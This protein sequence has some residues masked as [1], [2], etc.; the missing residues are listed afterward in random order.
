[1]HVSCLARTA[2]LLVLAS[3]AMSAQTTP[4]DVSGAEPTSPGLHQSAESELSTGA[5][6]SL[7][8]R[9][10]TGA[11]IMK[12][13]V[14]VYP[15]KQGENRYG[16]VTDASGQFSVQ[17]IAP[18]R[19][20]IRTEKVGY[21]AQDYGED[22]SGGPGAV[23]TLSSGQRINDLPFRMVAEGV[24]LGR[25]L[26]EDGAPV[27]DACACPR[28]PTSQALSSLQECKVRSKRKVCF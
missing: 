18:G 28:R 24:I 6:E 22:R 3:T 26:D 10:D 1:M 14:V 5:I 9:S 2:F 16:S 19:Y 13:Q 15:L 7:V 20:K 4:Q 11:P 8:V 17:G 23:L 12:A 21:L 27:Q 25:I